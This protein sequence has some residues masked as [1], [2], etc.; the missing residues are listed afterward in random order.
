M[1][2]FAAL[3]LRIKRLRK[4]RGLTQEKLAE[5]TGYSKSFIGCVENNTSIPSLETIVQIAT[6]L[7]VS[8]EYFLSGIQKNM[9][10]PHRVAEKVSLCSEDEQEL[11]ELFVD[12]IIEKKH[13]RFH[14]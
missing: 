8:P 9:E 2:D 5:L 13:V 1:I 3:G 11:V 10:R 4:S 14:K 7:E 6:V 12:A